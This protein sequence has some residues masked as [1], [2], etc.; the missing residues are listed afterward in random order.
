MKEL[1]DAKARSHKEYEEQA[2]RL[3]QEDNHT[4]RSIT[5]LFKFYRSDQAKDIFE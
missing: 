5:D 1:E 2:R 3:L 4:L